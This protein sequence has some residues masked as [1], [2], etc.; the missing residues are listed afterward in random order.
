MSYIL[1]V[2]VVGPSYWSYMAAV[3]AECLGRVVGASHVETGD[4]PRVATSD[5]REFFRLVLQATND[6][7]PENPPAS[8]SNCVLAITAIKRAGIVLVAKDYATELSL[9]SVLIS[10]L[11][12]PYVL[13]TEELRVA[14]NLQEFFI[15]IQQWGDEERYET[16]MGVC[17]TLEER[18]QR[19]T[20]F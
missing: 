3:M 7:V 9:Y 13:T 19:L 6:T 14:K 20:T 4:F 17:L 11:E 12:Q 15:Q 10:S 8:L 2:G 5:A 18:I 16:V 1:S